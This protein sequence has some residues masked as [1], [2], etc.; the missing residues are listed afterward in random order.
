[1]P[2]T[3]LA[4]ELTSLVGRDHEI[5]ELQRLVRGGARFVTLTGPGGSGKTR[6]AREA[7]RSLAADFPDGTFLVSLAPIRDPDYIAHVIA[8]TLEVRETGSDPVLQR[9]KNFLEKRRLLLLLDNFEQILDAGPLV[10]NLLSSCPQLQVLV[11]S[12][13]ALRV[14]G[15]REFPVPPLA[16]PDPHYLPADEDLLRYAS[17]GLFI[18]RARAANPNMQAD[19]GA[20]RDIATIC[21]RLDGLPLAIELAAA[22]T[23][24][25][26]PAAM[27]ARFEAGLPIL[28][29]G[30]RDLPERQRTLHAAIAWSYDLLDPVEQALFRRLSVFSGGCNLDSAEAVCTEPGPSGEPVVDVLET[31]ASLLDKNLVTQAKGIGPQPRFGMLETIR[32]FG[33]E[34]LGACG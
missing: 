29:G 16:I 18:D 31:I 7:A 24:L 3:N 2:A 19:S 6:L 23:K 12:R 27:L 4:L 1:M 32:E 21:A 30:A 22:R 28:T 15:E 9:L 11:T 8:Q 17:V 13:S 10:A 5:E 14:S 33:L 25:L 26:T 34:A 20:L